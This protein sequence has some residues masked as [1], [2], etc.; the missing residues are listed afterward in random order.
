MITTDKELFQWEK[1]RYVFIFNSEA[2][3]VQFYNKNSFEAKV[4]PISN[5]MAKN[6]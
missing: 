4:V 2:T 5:S 3:F 1:N 6:T